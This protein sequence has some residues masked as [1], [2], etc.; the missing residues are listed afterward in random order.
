MALSRF[1][2]AKTAEEE[3]N[4]VQ[5]GVPKST[6]YKNKWAYGIFEQWQRQ[7]LVKVPIVEVVC[8]FKNCDYHHVESLETPLVEMSFL[9]VNYWLTKFVQEVAKPSKERYPPRTLYGIVAGIRRFLA[10]KKPA[11]DKN[12]LSTFDKRY[13]LV[14]S[15][16]ARA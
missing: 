3:V 12:P 9:C 7:R 2:Q 11:E 15:V 5:N 4:L 6:H 1:R 10:E 8:L 16:K 13:D 14:I